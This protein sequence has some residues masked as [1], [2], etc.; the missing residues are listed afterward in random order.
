MRCCA[1]NKV[2]K[3]I[4]LILEGNLSNNGIHHCLFLEEL[5]KVLLFSCLM[6]GKL[7]GQFL[8]VSKSPLVGLLLLLDILLLVLVHDLFGLTGLESLLDLFP[9]TLVS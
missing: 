2:A 7:S 6:L 5:L 9:N 4:H 3:A 8:L 1:Y